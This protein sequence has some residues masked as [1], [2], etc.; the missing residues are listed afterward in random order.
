MRHSVWL[1]VAL[2]LGLTACASH[3]TALDLQ[4]PPVLNALVFT[5]PPGHPFYHSVVIEHISGMSYHSFWFAEANQNA[6]RPQVQKALDDSGM[7]A[8]TPISARYGLEIEFSK[9][10]TSPGGITLESRSRAIYRIIDRRTGHVVF[11]SPVE[12]SF[13]AKFV[14]LNENDAVFASTIIGAPID[15]ALFVFPTNFMAPG[16]F[17]GKGAEIRAHARNGDLANSGYGSRDGLIRSKQADFQ[18][19][20]QSIAK[21]VM[22]LA[23]DQKLPM[24]QVLPCLRNTDIAREKAN[25]TARGMRWVQEDCGVDNERTRIIY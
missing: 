2:C 8:A 18:M 7:A 23:A 20:K 5:V 14:G 9:L 17:T 12:A 21:F 24:T 11:Q 13:N 16:N 25:I 22:A 15:A 19:M 6:F 1:V 10:R 4:S 3:R